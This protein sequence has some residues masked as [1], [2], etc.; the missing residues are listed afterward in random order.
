MTVEL[1]IAILYSMQPM[2]LIVQ[3]LIRRL[4]E[5]DSIV[6]RLLSFQA[7]MRSSVDEFNDSPLFLL[8]QLLS[9]L[10]KVCG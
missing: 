8:S 9:Q 4:S 1:P 3:V 10:T 7:D 2:M 6:H 5:T